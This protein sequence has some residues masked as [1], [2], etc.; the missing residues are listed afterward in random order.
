MRLIITPYNTDQL[1]V[2]KKEII[3]NKWTTKVKLEKE[4]SK[5]FYTSLMNWF[6]H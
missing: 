2:N 4:I 1:S 3:Q 5:L 6:E